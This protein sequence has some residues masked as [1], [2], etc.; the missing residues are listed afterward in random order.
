MVAQNLEFSSPLTPQ[1]KTLYPRA[2][3]PTFFFTTEFRRKVASL[4]HRIH[5]TPFSAFQVRPPP[6]QCIQW[7]KSAAAI[8]T[9]SKIS[10]AALLFFSP[11]HPH[12]SSIAV[13]PY[14]CRQCRSKN[15]YHAFTAPK[16]FSSPVHSYVL[17]SDNKYSHAPTPC[18]G[19]S[20]APQ[21]KLIACFKFPF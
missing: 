4:P 8:H 17:K 19:L 2:H 13:T 5:R 10:P 20:P 1:D 16:H 3:P 7:S 18:H 15:S 21:S 12:S 14:T 9:F 6:L 11:R